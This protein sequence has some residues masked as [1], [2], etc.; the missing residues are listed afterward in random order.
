ML[1]WLD[2]LDARMNEMNGIV[3]R[4][5]AGAFSEKI[6]SLDRRVYHPHYLS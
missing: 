2:V 5:P 6:W 3:R 1:H 4:T